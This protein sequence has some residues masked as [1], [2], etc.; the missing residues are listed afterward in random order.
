MLLTDLR[1]LA[2][3]HPRYGFPDAASNARMTPRSWQRTAR[4][5]VAPALGTPCKIRT[6]R[7]MRPR[8]GLG[9]GCATATR[10]T[11]RWPTGFMSDQLA[12]GSRLRSTGRR[13]RLLQAARRPAGGHFV[14]PGPLLG[15]SAWTHC[16]K[17]AC[18]SQSLS[19]CDATGPS[20]PAWRCAFGSSGRAFCLELH[21]VPKLS[22]LQISSCRLER[23]RTASSS[24]DAGP[25]IGCRL[26]SRRQLRRGTAG[27]TTTSMSRSHSSSGYSMS[28]VRC[29]SN[30]RLRM[31]P[32]LSSQLRL[33]LGGGSVA[34][35]ADAADVILDPAICS[36]VP[37]SPWASCVPRSQSST[38][39]CRPDGFRAMRTRGRTSA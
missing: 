17:A 38:S 19:S 14:S 21:P 15:D 24:K 33:E 25:G 23:S 1:V 13:R 4:S 6:K 2:R 39:P 5:L 8:Q 31:R 11:E 30:D 18:A 7:R 3:R 36:R 10:P 37:C 34:G 29:R 12:S 20:S 16:V 35:L 27:A 26:P 22:S 9:S 32:L 28:A